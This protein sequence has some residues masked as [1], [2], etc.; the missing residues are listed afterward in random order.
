MAKQL[1]DAVLNGYDVTVAT[2]SEMQ[3]IADSH[4]KEGINHAIMHSLKAVVIDTDIYHSF[5]E[6]GIIT[7]H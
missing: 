1:L 2:D 4:G 7:L 5:I 6:H 3:S